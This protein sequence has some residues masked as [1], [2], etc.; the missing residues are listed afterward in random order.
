MRKDLG[1]HMPYFD[2]YSDMHLLPWLLD[3]LNGDS[4][5]YSGTLR[6][7]NQRL[8]MDI[9]KVLGTRAYCSYEWHYFMRRKTFHV[10]FALSPLRRKFKLFSLWK[11]KIILL[12][13]CFLVL[14]ERVFNHFDTDFECIISWTEV[15][16]VEDPMS[17]FNEEWVSFSKHISIDFT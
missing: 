13:I 16:K 14:D 7:T 6:H 5:K 10:N 3:N 4:A 8:K 2:K 1:I 17:C 15:F 12:E 11:M 9:F